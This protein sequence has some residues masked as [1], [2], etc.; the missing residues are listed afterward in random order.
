MRVAIP[1]G[2]RNKR[3]GPTR[4]WC[5]ERI[6]RD[7]S[8][9]CTSTW[10]QWRW[11]RRGSTGS[12][13]AAGTRCWLTGSSPVRLRMW[14]CSPI[15]SMACRRPPGRWRQRAAHCRVSGRAAGSGGRA[16][17]PVPE[18]GGGPG[19]VG[20]DRSWWGADDAAAGVLRAGPPPGGDGYR[21]C[22]GTWKTWWAGKACTGQPCRAAGLR[23]CCHWM[24]WTT[25]HSPR[26]GSA[27]PDVTRLRER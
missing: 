26:Q 25:G 21:A 13:W 14:T 19:G 2:R 17:R 11:P 20:R 8:V 15:R 24:R 10:G 6:Q 18:D 22:A 23:W 12:R 16:G 4:A 27:P 1:A 5:V 9:T 3:S 7:I